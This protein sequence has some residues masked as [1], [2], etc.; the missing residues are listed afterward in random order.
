MPPAPAWLLALSLAAPCS[1]RNGGGA[2][3][4]APG[5][6]VITIQARL[7]FGRGCFVCGSSCPSFDLEIHGDGREAFDGYVNV[8]VPGS[9]HNELPPRNVGMI[10][11]AI[12]RSHFF[13]VPATSRQSEDSHSRHVHIAVVSGPLVREIV[14]GPGGGDTPR[15][16]EWLYD[17]V[18]YFG[19]A[20]RWMDVTEPPGRSRAW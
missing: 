9:Y 11:D 12:T 6:D 17:V 4:A 15:E 14:Y 2:V 7:S 10:G 20:A 16:L 13:E 3:I 19:E 1:P 5:F 8:Q 18:L